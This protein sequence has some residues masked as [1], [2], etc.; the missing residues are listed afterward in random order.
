MSY[1]YLKERS[2]VLT[3]EGQCKMFNVRNVAD[4][5]IKISGAVRADKLMDAAG[6]G[7]S[8]SL[9]AV[10]DYLVEVGELREIPTYGAWQH[11]VFVSAKENS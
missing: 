7:N 9:M 4:Q 6:S 8:W 5:A 11:R 1:E 2:Y 3:K 10:V